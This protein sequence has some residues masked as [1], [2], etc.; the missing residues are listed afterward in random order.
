MVVVG[1]SYDRTAAPASSHRPTSSD[2]GQQETLACC[3]PVS[4]SLLSWIEFAPKEKAPVRLLGDGGRPGHRLK[5]LGV[6]ACFGWEKLRVRR[7]HVKKVRVKS[8][9]SLYS[10]N[11]DRRP[12]PFQRPRNLRYLIRIPK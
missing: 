7:V 2:R 5:N 4:G 6:C 12:S 3:E 1:A 8:L 10:I 9:L 11:F